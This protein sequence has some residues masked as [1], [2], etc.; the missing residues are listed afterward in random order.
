MQPLTR[1]TTVWLIAILVVGAL[2]R[3][4]PIWFGLP[5]LRARPDEETAVG[6]AA[7]MLGGDLNPHF[8]H[9]PS[10]TFYAFTA[11]FRVASDVSRVASSDPALS[12]AALLVVGRGLV[13]LAGTLTIAVLF[14]V[15]YRLAGALTGLLAA[16]VLAVSM[17]HIRESHFAMTD[18]LMTLFATLSLALILRGLEERSTPDAER[19]ALRLFSAAGVA[20]GLAASTKY[21]AAAILAAMAAAQAV[22]LAGAPG[23][24]WRVRSWMPSIAYAV[25]FGL[26]FLAATPYALLDWPAFAGDLWFD[27]THLSRGHNINLG[28]GWLYHLRTSLPYGLG[29][30]TFVAA[31]V[32]LFAM[33]RRHPRQAFVIW[34]FLIALYGVLGSG[35]TVFFRYMLPLVPMLCLAAAIGVREAA[36]WVAARQGVREGV[37][38][39]V[40]TAAVAGPALV[41]AVWFDVL[42]GRTDTRVLA[43]RWLAPRLSRDDSLHQ[44]GGSYARLDLTRLRYHEWYFDA[45]TES[46]GDPDG[47]TP[48]WLVFHESPLWTYA[49]VPPP[50]RTLARKKYALVYTVPATRRSRRSAAVY[51]LQD[52]FFMPI[53]GF[54]TIERPGPNIEIYKLLAPSR[55]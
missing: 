14:G 46:F 6:I 35:Y 49:Q 27:F 15:A 18:V 20:G 38:L 41:N 39:A 10:L 48:D 44:A 19:L 53:A 51:D 30:P 43:A 28:R 47:R 8:F 5:Y 40:L 7:R 17:L 21:N 31:A 29:I 23:S 2:L 32:G 22:L 12:P 37:V 34:A 52:A 26:G 1:R 54:Y 45:E 25:S 42:L 16:L 11:V 9:W 55:R 36:S 13:A 33:T 3:F 50:L 4:V 24:R